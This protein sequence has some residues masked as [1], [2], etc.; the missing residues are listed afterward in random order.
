MISPYCQ[1]ILLAAGLAAFSAAAPAGEPPAE[2][3]GGASLEGRSAG[4]KPCAVYANRPLQRGQA[5]PL[6]P[7]IRIAEADKAPVVDG[8][9]DDPCWAKAEEGLIATDE[10]SFPLK[11]TNSFKICQKDEVIYLAIR[12]PYGD[13]GGKK[14]GD[15]AKHDG[16]LWNGENIELFLDPD[17][18]DT[19]GYYQFVLTP[20][21]VTGDIYNNEPR[22]P[23]LRWEPKYEVK[24]QWTSNAWTIE[25]GIPL[26][27]FNYTKTIY[28]NFGLNLHRVNGGI[29]AWSPGHSEGFHFPHKFGEARGLKGTSVAKN[30]PGVFRSPQLK[31]NDRVIKATAN[32]SL[33]PEK[34]PALAAG[35]EVKASSAAAEIAFEANTRTDVAVWIEDGKGERVRHLAAGML[36]PNAPAPLKKNTLKQSVSWDYKDDFGRKVPAGSYKARVG[37]GSKAALDKEIGRNESPNQINAIAADDK[38]F[39]YSYEGIRDQWS[40]I[41]KYDRNGKFVS[42]LLPPPADVPVEK[43]KGLNIIDY[44]P[45]GQVRFGGRELAETLPS[46][47]QPFPQSLLINSKGQLIF[48]GSEYQGGPGRFY[49]INADG[50]LPEDFVGPYLKDINWLIWYNAWAKRFHFALDPLDENIIYLSGLKEQHRL[51][52]SGSESNLELDEKTPGRLTFYNAICRVRWGQDAPL[53]T[54]IGKR[55]VSGAAASDKPGEFNDPQGIA[56]DKDNNLWVCDRRNNRIQ[57][58]NHDGK[59]LRQIAHAGPYEVRISK[60]TGEAYVLGASSTN[61]IRHAKGADKP[62]THLKAVI[63]TKYAAGANPKVLAQTRLLGMER[64]KGYYDSVDLDAWGFWNYWWTMAL[65]ES[66]DKPCLWVVWGAGD[67]NPG[68]GIGSDSAKSLARVRDLGDKFGE[69][70]VLIGKEAPQPRYRIAAGWESDIICAGHEWYDANSGRYLG[71]RKGGKEVAA[72]RDGRWVIREGYDFEH[73]AVYPESWARDPSVQALT[74]WPLVPG[75]LTRAGERG[76]Y[77]APN[78]DVYV[79]RY[80]EWFMATANRGGIEGPDQ[81]ATV[82]RYTIDGK[83]V[84]QRVVYELSGGACSPVADI[85]G[86]IYVCDNLGRKLGQFYEED[87]APNLPS[88]APD[89][90]ISAAEWESLRNGKTVFA[91]YRKFVQNPLIRQVGAVYKFGPKGG[92]L[93]WRAA[94][95]DYPRHTPVTNKQGKVGLWMDWGYPPKPMPTRPATHWSSTW[96]STGDGREGI[97]PV[98]H[99]G[100][101]WEFLGVSPASGRYTKGHDGCVCFNLRFCADDF[102]R[103]YVP[104]AHRNTIRML[105]TAGNELLRIGRY[106]NLDSGPNARLKEPNVPLR[107]PTATA[108]SKR[109]LYAVEEDIFRVLR[110]KLGYE[111]VRDAKVEAR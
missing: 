81:H 90:K 64:K 85:K 22:D 30:A 71:T 55:N 43:L 98:W 83:L 74:N 59:F 57:I 5:E 99:D 79:M 41:M 44:G 34:P 17:N 2:E 75:S 54:F 60:K 21:D 23:E 27:A 73:M 84:G 24:S 105:D 32:P 65:D 9:L 103:T 33:V 15:G 104:A 28:E 63:L 96:I 100:V 76:F 35:P 110:I 88:W 69:P 52:N 109:Y 39:V 93:L 111:Q 36:G 97:F 47:E 102:G 31:I 49:K 70:E 3:R 4:E 92:G 16:A 61:F 50:S 19:P 38:G 68:H 101:E 94:Q 51:D 80:Y 77:V 13:K 87:I 56:F 40:R 82:D 89:Y 95:G 66:G 29:G 42:M 53:E 1:A 45:D 48:A 11:L 14:T 8:A 20:F 72:T 91:G 67:I 108:L 18:E 107:F 26:A 12:C 6:L 58:F 37:V 78:S 46:I 62:T 7:S 10:Y 25:Y 106:G 86:N